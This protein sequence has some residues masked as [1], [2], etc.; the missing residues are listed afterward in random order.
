VAFPDR[1]LAYCGNVHPAESLADLRG[2][3]ERHALPVAEILGRHI[4]VGL[5]LP[6][7]SLQGINAVQVDEFRNWFESNGLS[8]NTLNAFP[9]GDFHAKRVKERVYLPDWTDPLRTEYTN[10]AAD[11]LAELLPESGLGSLSTLPCAYKR[12]SPDAVAADF[13]PQLIE[14]TRHLGRIREQRG[15][16]IRLAI[17]P[18]RVASRGRGCG[19]QNRQGSDQFRARD[20]G[21]EQPRG[22]KVPFAVRRRTLPAPDDRVRE[23]TVS[24][25]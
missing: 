23:R 11:F 18:R 4:A 8:T 9:F 16:T 24:V 25:R 20:S 2:Q 14:A 17:E 7:S 12:L 19:N 21:A 13:F 15:R 3:L 1:P 22:A 6:R 10:K 5:W